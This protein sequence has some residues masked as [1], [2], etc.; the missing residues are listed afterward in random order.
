MGRSVGAFLALA[1]AFQTASAFVPGSGAALKGAG[2]V[3]ARQDS[4][5]ASRRNGIPSMIFDFPAPGERKDYPRPPLEETSEN[6]RESAAF[7]QAFIDMPRPERPLNVAVIGAGLAGLS[8]AKYLSDAGHK[9]IVLEARDVLGGKV[10]AWQDK[11]GDWIETGLH[12]FFGAYPNVNQMFTELGIRDRL[13]WKSHSMIFAMPGQQT[14]DGFQRFSRFEFPALLPAPLNGLVAILLNNEM[15]TFPEKIQFGIGLLPAIL[16]G[17]KYVEECDSLTVS[18]WMKKQ[19]VPDRVNDEVFIAMA[20]ALNFIDP[21]NLSMTV[22]LTALNRFLQETHGSKMAFLDGP[23]PTRLCQPM[24]DYM[25]ERG[26]ELRMEQRI[27]SILLND[28][29]TVKGLKMQDGS[30]VVADA[31]VS[32]MP[33]DIL[34]LMLP[35]EWK[36]MPYFE[37]LNGLNGVPVI[38]IHMWFDRKLTT[39]DHLLFSRSPL[40][41][42]YADMSLTCNGYRDDDKS[43]LELVFAPAKDWIGKP[44]EAIIEA[45]MEELY[46]LF[47]NELNKD[48][49]GAKLLKSAVVK[50]PLSVYEATAGRELYRPVQTSPISN[51][52]L[53]GCFTKQKYLASMEGATFSGKLAAKALSDAAIA[54][55]IPLEKAASAVAA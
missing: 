23:P 36:P 48:G 41:S 51:F 8:C 13:Q 7:S 35:Q 39:V 53:A 55:T 12:I 6:Q 1:V 43:M 52:F 45:T 15:L 46:R 47:P 2:S 27:S 33:V 4:T 29:K 5:R 24:A 26:G 50:T 19:G 54:G 20:K 44:D 17:Q 11:D 18:Q 3:G 10:S 37:K 49:S 34:K 28:D 25:L 31:Y 14:A 16:F 21:E 32:T 42:V 30:T 9:P 22:V 38:N 40:L